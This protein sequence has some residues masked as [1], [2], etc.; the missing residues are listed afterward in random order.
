MRH[1]RPSRKPRSHPPRR[2]PGK[3]RS[4][5][6]AELERRSLRLAREVGN[7]GRIV[8]VDVS[9]P[10]LAVAEARV[11]AASLDN[12]TLL[13]ADA[14]T[15]PFEPA[16]FELAFSR[17]GVMFFDDA[18]AA[19]S[20]V[21]AALA[22]NGRLAFV[23]WRGLDENPLFHVP[24]NAVL[25]LVP[26]P[27]D[28]SPDDPGPMAFADPGRVRRVLTAAGFGNV[29]VDTF[30]THMTLGARGRRRRFF[31]RHRSGGASARKRRRHH[32]GRGRRASRRG[33]PR[34]RNGGWR[35]ARRGG[36]GSCA[37]MS[38]SA[39]GS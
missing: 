14:A 38:R 24:R 32:A 4:T 20:N 12:V 35:D 10:M 9:Q 29:A 5:S 28:A 3:P 1:S 30:D 39:S 11:R 34:L 23:C 27:P 7:A 2:G 17:F 21:R 25:P 31:S 18:I 26:A 13:R 33:D 8:G 22:P 19:L 36:S 6:G 16:S 37:P 15:H